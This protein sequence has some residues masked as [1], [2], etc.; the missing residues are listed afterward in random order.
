[1][2]SNHL[3]DDHPGI[4]TNSEAPFL[5]NIRHVGASGFENGRVKKNVFPHSSK[6]VLG[7]IALP[8]VRDIFRRA[9]FYLIFKCRKMTLASPIIVILA[10]AV[11]TD[12]FCV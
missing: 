12:A 10:K 3:H 2:T 4:G 8:F 11:I 1:M 9:P 5:Q 6:L 7:H